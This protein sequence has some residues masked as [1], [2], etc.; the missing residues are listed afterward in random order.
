MTRIKR[1]FTGSFFH[2]V[3]FLI[4][5]TN[6]NAQVSND[7]IKHTEDKYPYTREGVTFSAKQ[8]IVPAVLITIGTIGALEKDFDIKVRD[9]VPD[10]KGDT[11]IDD[12]FPFVA[13]TSVYVLNWSG[14]E[15]KHN[16]IDRSVIFGT[17]SIITIGSVF[18]IKNITSRNRPDN[19]NDDSFPS[20]HTA[21]AFMG[22]EFLR[23]EF[24]DQSIWYG[25]A[26]YGIAACTGFLRI[27][28]NKH[29]LSDVLVGAGI[30]ILGTNAAYWLYPEIRKLYEG[31]FLD[32]ATIIPFAS[33]RNLGLAFSAR[34]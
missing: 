4:C 29:W 33:N 30:G 16:F 20:M 25:V 13:P 34:F 17:S 27:Y 31:T 23:Q 18:A 2:I 15:G 22:A 5:V 11:F 12:I 1:M 9:K 26:G 21:I 24:K 10:Y 6:L 19:S 28:N 8:L 32:N 3:L 7:T 14:I